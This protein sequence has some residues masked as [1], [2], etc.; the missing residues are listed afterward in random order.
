[1]LLQENQYSACGAQFD[2]SNCKMNSMRRLGK[3]EGE[4]RFFHSYTK[5]DQKMENTLELDIKLDDLCDTYDHDSCLSR[6]L[7]YFKK[8]LFRLPCYWLLKILEIWSWTGSFDW[9]YEN[10]SWTRSFDWGYKCLD[11]ATRRSRTCSF[12][13]WAHS[14]QSERKLNW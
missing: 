3:S 5:K 14:S 12:D 8:T 6:W 13:L 4:K 11:L 10:W 9:G 7:E 2:N 1:L